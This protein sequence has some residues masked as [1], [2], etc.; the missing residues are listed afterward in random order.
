[1]SEQLG[2]IGDLPG[3]LTLGVPWVGQIVSSPNEEDVEALAVELALVR[4]VESSEEEGAELFNQWQFVAG[5]RGLEGT[6]VALDTPH[7]VAEVAGGWE[8]AESTSVVEEMRPH[9]I[10][11]ALRMRVNDENVGFCSSLVKE[12]F[13][14]EGVVPVSH[15]VVQVGILVAY[16]GNGEVTNLVGGS[17]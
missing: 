10:E 13:E 12:L 5:P 1:M 15:G 4:D 6:V 16:N 7:K 9:H 2:F 11:H 17:G 8:F 14:Q 3:H